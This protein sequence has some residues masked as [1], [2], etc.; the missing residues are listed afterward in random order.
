MTWPLFRQKKIV[1]KIPL[2]NFAEPRD[3][4]IT[5]YPKV[6][7]PMSGFGIHVAR[8][9]ETAGWSTGG[10]TPGILGALN[11]KSSIKSD[12]IPLSPIYA[13]VLID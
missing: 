4:K 3:V 10:A 1:G 8:P 12:T 2:P 6:A 9:V 7:L 13:L 5:G 11:T